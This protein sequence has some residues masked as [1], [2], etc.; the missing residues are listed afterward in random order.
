MTARSAFDTV[1]VRASFSALLAA[2][3][4]AGCSA[5]A[6]EDAGEQG[7]ADSIANVDNPN[8]VVGPVSR[9]LWDVV[10]ISDVGRR[11]G[12]DP[13]N[14]PYP[15]YEWHFGTNGI[16]Y[17]WNTSTT[18]SST[19]QS[20]PDSRS[21]LEKWVG[22][23]DPP[24]L[25]AAKDWNRTHHGV[26]TPGR[27]WW[28]GLCTG[29]SAAAVSENPAIRPVWARYAN[30]H[31]EECFTEAPDCTKFEIGDVNGLL[32][33]VYSDAPSYFT[34]GRCDSSSIT[35]DRYGRID[36]N[37]NGAGCKGLNPASLLI[38]LS[39]RLKRDRR[40]LVMNYQDSS[41][42]AAVWNRPVYAYEVSRLSPISE[43]QAA[44]LVARNSR[45]TPQGRYLWNTNA[46]GFVRVDFTL[47]YV[48]DTD[49]GPA[50]V[51]VS[52]RSMTQALKLAAV[53][54]LDRLP[55]DPSAQLIGGEYIEDSSIGTNLLTV[56][57]FVWVPTGPSDD[58][59]LHPA[60]WN[61]YPH[62]PYVVTSRVRELAA[63][64]S[65]Y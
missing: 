31:V 12:L 55:S 2:L 64:A 3:A 40:A 9:R 50:T 62:N 53:L 21:P 4:P 25:T 14:A 39:Q 57:P 24:R 13:Q 11:L 52:G 60:W 58:D 28:W 41:L 34:G 42:T 45:P 47:D 10:P 7:S 46:R 48:A 37:A 63:L 44:R 5:V 18:A 29:W 27:E 15:D 61:S 20:T 49:D 54:E 22:M 43:A 6:T 23:V 1:F 59:A 16:D 56:P 17:R 51:P 32:A 19:S 65:H 8:Y 33:E 36:R 30:G 26:D 35:F 38:V